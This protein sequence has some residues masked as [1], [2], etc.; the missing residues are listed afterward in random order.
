MMS[1]LLFWGAIV[2]ATVVLGLAPLLLWISKSTRWQPFGELVW[3]VPT[4]ER[5][6]AL[7]FDDGPES[8]VVDDVLEALQRRDAHATFFLTGEGIS[9]HPDDARK[10]LVAGH[11]IGNHSYSHRRMTFRSNEFIRKEIETTYSL[12]RSI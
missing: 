10:I 9:K 4:A 6:V 1:H 12:I 11:E 5:L 2:S 3:H 7:T 8:G